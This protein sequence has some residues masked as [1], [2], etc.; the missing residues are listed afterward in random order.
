MWI[1][2]FPPKFI[3]FAAV[4]LNNDDNKSLALQ[5]SQAL[6]ITVHLIYVNFQAM[7]AIF[8]FEVFLIT[9]DNIGKILVN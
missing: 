3:N 8:S 1:G 9:I 6:Q 5:I 4:Y 7:F 2:I